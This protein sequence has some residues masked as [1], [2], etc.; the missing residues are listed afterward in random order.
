MAPSV[1]LSGFSG[2]A[3]I[4]NSM[5]D[6]HKLQGSDKPDALPEL[7]HILA[8]HNCRDV[9]AFFRLHKHFGLLDGEVIVSSLNEKSIV[10]TVSPRFHIGLKASHFVLV[11]GEWHAIQAVSPDSGNYD[12]VTESYAHLKPDML[13]EVSAFLLGSGLDK[14]IGLC[15]AYGTEFSGHSLVETTN[16]ADRVQLIIP[17]SA[18]G[19]APGGVET[20]WA[21]DKVNCP[22]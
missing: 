7:F 5:P 21:V 14:T 22:T 3:A 13:R 10:V 15:F 8:K 6:I 20:Y 2:S 12:T 18:A 17:A 4:H 9:L 11:D 16:E 1:H 19:I